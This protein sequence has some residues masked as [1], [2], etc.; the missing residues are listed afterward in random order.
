MSEYLKT[1]ILFLT[2]NRLDTT[3]RIFEAI[4]KARPKKLYV[5]S[6]GPRANVQGEG[7]KVK[8]VRDFI[9]SNIDWECE[10][11][12]LFRDK[13]LGC[14]LAVSG[15]IDWFF[16]NEEQGIILEDDCLPNQS[17]FQFCEEL[18]E[19][20]K[21]NEEIAAISGNNFNKEKIGEADYYFSKIPHIWGWATWRRTWKKYDVNMSGF[22]EFKKNREIKKI[23]S[24]KNVQNYWLY[25]L[26]EVYNNKI[27]TWDYQLSFSLFIN[28]SFCICP[29][30]NLVSNI[31][32]G[33]EFTNTVV[34]DERVSN[35]RS[36]EISF[37]LIHPQE[38]KYL[39]KNNDCDNIIALKNY[40][41]KMILKKIGVFDLVKKMYIRLKDK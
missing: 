12:T 37:P 19:K 23:W 6:D 13:N 10:V 34:A 15:A 41:I 31:G 20:Y 27:N 11:K 24:A 26:N 18:L 9:E 2:F 4:K 21:D 14:R 3:K 40:K 7:S 5:A 29:N 35:L 1:P 33:K 8:E 32:F 36:N 22:P 30:V 25:I 38:I 17:F 16:E 39:E 28:N